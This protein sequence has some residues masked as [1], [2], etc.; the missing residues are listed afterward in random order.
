MIKTTEQQRRKIKAILEDRGAI[1]PC[2]RCGH[3]E[4]YIG[5]FGMDRSIELEEKK[6]SEEV[7]VFTVMVACTNC[8]HI[9]HHSLK[10]LGLINTKKPI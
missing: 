9:W 3:N 2:T 1:R 10:I 5:G 7:K 8:G 4:F 6:E